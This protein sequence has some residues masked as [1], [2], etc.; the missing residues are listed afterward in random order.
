MDPKTLTG[1]GPPAKGNPAVYELRHR[2]AQVLVGRAVHGARAVVGSTL[3]VECVVD[4]E[5]VIPRA[6]SPFHYCSL[7]CVAECVNSEEDK[8]AR[9]G[10]RGRTKNMASPVS[11]SFHRSAGL[12]GDT[13]TSPPGKGGRS[14]TAAQALQT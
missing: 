3:E 13:V 11:Y 5:P 8:I 1:V 9:G 7:D 6:L 12:S 4:A 2:E 10:W 14:P